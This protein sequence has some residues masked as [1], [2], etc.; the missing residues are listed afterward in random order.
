MRIPKLERWIDAFGEDIGTEA[1][2][3][4]KCRG[5][6]LT[7]PA[8]TAWAEKCYHDP[9]DSEDAYAECLMTALNA[10]IGGYGTEAIEGR[11]VDRY[12]FNIQ[13]EYVNTGDT[14]STTVLLDHETDRLQITTFG[15]WVEK[16]GERRQVA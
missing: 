3:Y 8:V 11:Y 12:H 2:A 15:D 6:C 7:H 10:I 1:Y 4:A 5:A 13:A 9:R 14:Y 16:Y